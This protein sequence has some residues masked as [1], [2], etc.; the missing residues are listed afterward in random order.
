MS[1]QGDIAPKII[2]SISSLY[3]DSN[4]VL[5]EFIDNSLDSAEQ[6]FNIEDNTYTRPI[7]ITLEISGKTN[8]DGSVVIIDNCEGI[9]NL[10]SVVKSFGNSRK[11]GQ[12]ETNGQFG[13]GMCSFIA[14]CD[15][16]K[17]ITKN[18][19]DFTKS[20]TILKKHFEV[21]THEEFIFEDIERIDNFIFDSGTKIIL[22]SFNKNSWKELNVEL[23]KNEI[24][25]HFEL[26]L[27]RS[28]LEIKLINNGDEYV[29]SSFNYPSYNGNCIDD[30]MLE[31]G[32]VRL[33]IKTTKGVDIK[34]RPVFIIKG[35]R[36]IEIHELKQFKSKN[37]GDIWNHP[38]IT[39]YLDLGNY[40]EP[41][42]ARTGFA[43]NDREKSSRIF[44]F[45]VSKEENILSLIRENN[46]EEQERHYKQLE[47]ILSNA[48][49]KL[50][51]IDSMNFRTDY[52]LGKDV[53]LEDGGEGVGGLRVGLDYLDNGK[54]DEYKGNNPSA[55]SGGDNLLNKESDSTFKDEN[56]DGSERKKSGLNIRIVD[57]DP[58]VDKETNKQIKSILLGNTIEIFRK[59]PEFENRVNHSR[60][61]GL[62]ISQR[63]ITYLA[64]EITVHYKDKYYMRSGQPE[65]NKKMFEG[66]VDS[67]Y[68]F[69]DL[70]KD[71]VDK[72][73]SLWSK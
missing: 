58:N 68:L 27:V 66:L 65:Y 36:I 12:V 29:C 20:I 25:K 56:L 55:T 50:A 28:N 52:V 37:K 39:G 8:K 33:F 44:E 47:D 31:D 3:S 22:S 53:K 60:G 21:D 70:L 32:K 62:R 26:L 30:S 13:F 35:R 42:L 24:E 45:L 64:G 18:I 4:R 6:Y 14:S 57:R 72:D 16:L 69:E 34:K 67:I 48:L 46:E 7:K 49:S 5:L 40:I 61:G 15:D 71:A 1:I 17:I 10:E 9:T 43:A 54:N 41:D 51:K 23:I 59:H 63:L 19:N 2:Q 11:K 73:L 38:N